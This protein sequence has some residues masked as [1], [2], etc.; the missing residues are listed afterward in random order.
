[1]RH[2]FYVDESGDLGWSFD[3]PY[4]RG[5]SSRFLVIAA[6]SLPVAEVRRPERAMKELFKASRWDCR[7]EKKWVD[8]PKPA[9]R[10][11]AHKA[12][13]LTESCH[14]IRY[15]AI[16]VDKTRVP[17]HLRD[18]NQLYAHMVRLL[19][20]QEMSQHPSVDFI[21][22]PRSVKLE[23][24]NSL[25]DYLSTW[26]GFELGATT[27]LRTQS[28]ESRYSKNLQFTDMLAGVVHAHFEFGRSECFEI[29]SPRLRLEQLEF[30][31]E[32]TPDQR[33][34]CRASRVAL[35]RSCQVRRS[36]SIQAHQKPSP[37]ASSETVPI[38]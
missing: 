7:K 1:M 9:R 5:G 33:L 36:R 23:S 6:M 11:F 16:V 14:E 22:D 24:G 32:P 3:Q 2:I 20:A 30:P 4:G 35:A 34:G 10:H 37:P 18:G 29:L 15:H 27:V 31:V 13:Q 17:P 8:A 28:V 12:V 19:L 26:L 21:P 38:A 25:H